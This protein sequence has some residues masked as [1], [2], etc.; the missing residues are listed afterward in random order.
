MK[1]RTKNTKI[2]SQRGQK[3]HQSSRFTLTLNSD[4]L[5]KV[6]NWLASQW[7]KGDLT[8]PS[9]S[10]LIRASLRAYQE[11]KI[12]LNFAERDAHGFKRETGIHWPAD[13]LNFYLSVPEGKRTAAVE[14]SLRV[15][16]DLITR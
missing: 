9:R 2:I 4:L 6:D 7:A 15:Y 13:L 10:F 16:F 3:M 12:K 11:G 8:Y 14:E 5:T 1:I